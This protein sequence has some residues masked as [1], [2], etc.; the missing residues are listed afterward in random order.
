MIPRPI[1]DLLA[2]IG[3]AALVAAWNHREKVARVIAEWL[4]RWADSIE[5][6][7]TLARKKRD[8]AHKNRMDG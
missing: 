1:L 5:F 4:V 2:S 7:R 8:S 3:F 6:R